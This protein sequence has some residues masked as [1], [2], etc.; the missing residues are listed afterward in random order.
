MRHA[1]IGCLALTAFAPAA[2]GEPAA[3]LTQDQLRAEA[4]RCV[5]SLMQFRSVQTDF[6]PG[7]L[8]KAKNETN[9]EGQ[10][11]PPKSWSWR[12][13]VLPFMEQALLYKGV[14]EHSEGFKIPGTLP[15][16]ELNKSHDLKAQLDRMPEWMTIERHKKAVGQTIYRRVVVKEKP[17][18]LIL[19]ESSELVP[20]FRPTD[21]LELAE[22]KPLPKLGGNF[23]AGFFALCGDGKIRFLS[24]TLTEKEVRKVL[25]TGGGVRAIW[26]GDR[27]NP[28]IDIA[29]LDLGK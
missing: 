19:V 3:K 28:E 12:V 4:K 11:P 25:L 5:Y 13:A 27:N 16:D 20:W 8:E 6:F 23:S 24:K 14:Q 26:D 18:L 1:I 7:G 17:E 9:V 29:N 21:D 10:W 2:C 15:D 22:G